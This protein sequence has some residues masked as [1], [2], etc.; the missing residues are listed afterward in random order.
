MDELRFAKDDIAE[1]S[2]NNLDEEHSPNQE[3]RPA[4][5]NVM[6][7]PPVV[8]SAKP[9][10]DYSKLDKPQAVALLQSCKQEL[11]LGRQDIQRQMPL[12][13]LQDLPGRPGNRATLNQAEVRMLASIYQSV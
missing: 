7:P 3:N 12:V 8:P 13:S 9:K 4:A 6:K 11:Q 5:Y 2:C 10:A 1:S